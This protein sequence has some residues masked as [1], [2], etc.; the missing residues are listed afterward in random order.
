M[1]RALTSDDKRMPLTQSRKEFGV[2]IVLENITAEQDL[3][4][5]RQDYLKTITQFNQAQFS[6]RQAIGAK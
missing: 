3:T 2:G 1:P 4:R 6:L 5:S